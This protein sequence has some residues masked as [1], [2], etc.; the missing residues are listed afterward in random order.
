VIGA[1]GVLYETEGVVA[2]GASVVQSVEET[3]VGSAM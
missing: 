1:V 2:A 3:L